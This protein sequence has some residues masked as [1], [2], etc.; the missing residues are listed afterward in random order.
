MR[1]DIEER[2]S[3]LQKCGARPMTVTLIEYMDEIPFRELVVYFQTA[4]NQKEIKR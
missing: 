2:R 3:R 1:E 4:L